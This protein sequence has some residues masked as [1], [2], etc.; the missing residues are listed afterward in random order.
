MDGSIVLECEKPSE[1]RICIKVKDTGEG[2]SK[3]NINDIF[4]PFHRLEGKSAFVEGTGIGLN[5]AKGFVESMD[6][7]IKVDSVLGEGSCFTIDLPIGKA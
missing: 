2:I 1:G 7:T 4:Q 5:I 3:E 6:G